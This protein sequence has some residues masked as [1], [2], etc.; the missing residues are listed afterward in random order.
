MK[1]SGAESTFNLWIAF[2][3]TH[4]RKC[5]SF[6]I[7]HWIFRIA[8]NFR[9]IFLDS[10][11]ILILL[12]PKSFFQITSLFLYFAICEVQQLLGNLPSLWVLWQPSCK[13]CYTSG[14]L[15]KIF[16]FVEIIQEFCFVCN[17][18]MKKSLGWVISSLLA[19]G[20]SVFFYLWQE[21]SDCI[22]PVHVKISIE[23]H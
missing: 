10:S 2:S 18:V 4:H 1:N 12:P 22:I 21:Y 16:F 15:S 9:L 8:F 7:F 5:L 13:G 20:I 6:N 14:G 23:R 17:K 3:F 19:K 11:L